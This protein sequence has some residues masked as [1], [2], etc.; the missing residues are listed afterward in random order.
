MSEAAYTP[1]S[2]EALDEAERQAL[3]AA[4]AEALADPRPDIP[5]EE[6][7]AEIMAEIEELERRITA[8]LPSSSA[9]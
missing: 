6:V 7:R 8:S 3:I 2:P 4:V 9:A 5:H 1:L